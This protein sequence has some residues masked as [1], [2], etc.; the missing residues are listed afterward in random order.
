MGIRMDG[1]KSNQRGSLVYLG[2]A[3]CY[4]GGTETKI[5]WKIQAEASAWRNV[6]VVMGEAERKGA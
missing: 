5:H 6:E 4:D 1:K 2:E 3:V